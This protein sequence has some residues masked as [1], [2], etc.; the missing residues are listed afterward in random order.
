MRNAPIRLPVIFAALALGG[1][2]FAQPGL[3]VV[4]H[5]LK[6][7]LTILLL[8]D[9]TVPTIAYY[10]FFKVGSRNERPGITGISHLFE[11]MMF[12]GSARYKPKELDKYIEAAGGS[13]NAFTTQ[14]ST[15]YSEEVS[16]SA[17]D[18]VIDIESDRMRALTLD[19]RNL[20]QERGIVKEERRSSLEDQIAPSMRELLWN[21][22]FVSHPYRWEVL[23]F[24]KDIDAISLQD[25]KSYF[26]TYYSP[27]NAVLVLVGDLKPAYAIRKIQESYGSIPAGP[28]PK[29]VV[30]AEPPQRGEVRLS[31]DRQAEEP[32]IMMG[33]KGVSIHD[34]DDPVLDVLTEILSGGQSSRLYRSLIY[35][36]RIASETWAENES[37]Y[38]PGLFTV[39]AQ[40]QEGYTAKECE[41]AIQ[42]VIEDIQ[43][44][45]VTDRELQKAK[46]SLKVDFVS[47][48]K[49]NEQL[50]GL[51]AQYEALFGDWRKL[52]ALQNRRDAVT[53]LDIQWA[54]RKYLKK[55][56]RTV[57]E[58]KA[59]AK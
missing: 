13:A 48:F 33:Y 20:E 38:D 50:A 12:N 8:E 46:N 23:G 36:K 57:V 31:Y 16:S 52:Y 43:N 14:D 7:G 19:T 32:S 22:A 40:A 42:G 34:K 24:M 45:G 44:N 26:R 18:R 15:E 54:A 3:N 37:K 10:T 56:L 17:L 41:D 29:K 51:L 25:A 5:K 4:R 58:L 28:P 6:N 2:C 47:R 35:D 9:H 30:N 39:Y 49:T 27:N 21:Y 55:S 1:F 53:R 11:H 59:V